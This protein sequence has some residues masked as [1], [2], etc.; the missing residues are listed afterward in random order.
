LTNKIK[1]LIADDHPL[2]LEGLKQTL[3]KESGFSVACVARNGEEALSFIRKNSI[4][5]VVLDIEMPVL[6]G[7]KAARIIRE[8]NLNDGI[9][10]LSMYKDELMFSEAMDIGASG[11][12]LKENAIE[13]IVDCIKRV[14]DGYN[15]VSPALSHF[16]VKHEREF[17]ELAKSIPSLNNL[18]KTERIILRMIAEDKTSKQISDEL[19][20]SYKTIENHRSNISRKLN[21]HGTHSLIKFALNNKSVL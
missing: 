3:E 2:M 15:Y 6:N 1:I 5:I 18:T 20:V 10:F 17:K 7:F 13:D 11:Y 14:N 19:H 21:I 9:I 8:E 4:D 16:L 12:V